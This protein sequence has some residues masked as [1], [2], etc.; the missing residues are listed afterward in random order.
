[1]KRLS[2]IALVLLAV[3][4]LVMIVGCKSNRTMISSIL[5]QPEK[6]MD[7]D[8]VVAGRV[9]RTYAVNL[10]IAEM[11]AYQIDDG[12]GKIWVITKT[13]VPADGAEV[14]LKGTVS[15]GLKFGHEIF[16][17]VIREGERRTR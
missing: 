6:F 4:S 1:M 10:L 2:I 17:A 12:S 13:G 15:S 7:R 11:G 8:V 5:Q 16:G 9:T 14:G 3:V